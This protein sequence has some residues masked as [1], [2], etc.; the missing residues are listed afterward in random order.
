[1]DTRQILQVL[2]M[3]EERLLQEGI[4]KIAMSDDR[5]FGSLS[6]EENLAH[7][8]YL[9]EGTRKFALDPK[10]EGKMNRHLTAIQMCLSN[11][12]WYT[13]EELKSHNR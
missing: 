3:Y 4:P 5:Y 6:K 2:A 7:A 8:H 9:I 13:L 12:L 11:A 10:K 1:M